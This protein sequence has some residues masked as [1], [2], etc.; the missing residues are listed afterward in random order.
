MKKLNLK[1]HVAIALAILSANGSMSV[2]AGGDGKGEQTSGSIANAPATDLSSLNDEALKKLYIFEEIFDQ[3]LFSLYSKHNLQRI[4]VGDSDQRNYLKVRIAF[5]RI[6]SLI[7]KPS[8][9]QAANIEDVVGRLEYTLKIREVPEEII[10]IILRA[11]LTLAKDTKNPYLDMFIDVWQYITLCVCKSV[12]IAVGIRPYEAQKIYDQALAKYDQ[13][14]AKYD[15]AYAKCNQPKAK[16]SQ[17]DAEWAQAYKEWKEAKEIYDQA[18]AEVN[19]ANL[20]LHKAREELD[21]ANLELD[22]ADEECA[23]EY[24]EWKKANAKCDKAF[25]ELE[26]ANLELHKARE[27]LDKAREELDKVSEELDKVSEELDKASDQWNVAATAK[28]WYFD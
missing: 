16:F 28:A 6:K 25:E 8:E 15:Q 27:E 2:F 9:N 12:N 7:N 23:Q 21:K 20:E 4:S 19:K 13:A 17:V 24:E 10:D 14:L 26:K 11:L 1:K 18:F 5:D 22:K 3:L